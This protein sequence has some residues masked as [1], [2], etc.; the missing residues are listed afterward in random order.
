MEFF[1]GLKIACSTSC[2]NV[3]FLTKKQKIVRAR[4]IIITNHVWNVFSRIRTC[5]YLVKMMQV[6]F[7]PYERQYES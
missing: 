7:F 1:F 5:Y 4:R 2:Q 6:Q 3:C